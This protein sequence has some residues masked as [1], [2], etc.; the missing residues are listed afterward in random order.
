MAKKRSVKVYG[1]S[2]YKYRGTPTIMLKGVWLKE[3][4]FDVGDYISVTCCRALSNEDW[5]GTDFNISFLTTN[6]LQRK[7][8]NC[9]VPDGTHGGVRGRGLPPL[10]LDFKLCLPFGLF[11]FKVPSDSS[12][13]GID[14]VPPFTV[15]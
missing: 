6:L 5:R 1:Q 11:F 10:L 4:G 7:L 8:R 15:R 3:A 9:R 12:C 2:G 13:N 14:A